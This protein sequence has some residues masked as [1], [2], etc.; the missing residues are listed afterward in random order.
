MTERMGRSPHEMECYLRDPECLN[1]GGTASDRKYGRYI[2]RVNVQGLR[3]TA[4]CRPASRDAQSF[5]FS[6]PTLSLHR[7][8]TPSLWT[9]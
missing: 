9:Y 6:K 1:G 5:A 8:S 2:S 7:S 3:V 4:A